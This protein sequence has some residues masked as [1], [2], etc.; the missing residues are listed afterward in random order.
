MT[1]VNSRFGIWLDRTQ[2]IRTI[3]KRHLDDDFVDTIQRFSKSGKNFKI[4]IKANAK[5]N[6][7]QTEVCSTWKLNRILWEYLFDFWSQTT[8]VTILFKY[9][10]ILLKS[11]IELYWNFYLILVPMKDHCPH[12]I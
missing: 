6:L 12:L 9:D 4:S 10:S 8:I 1:K 5:I 11:Q 3:R 7:I 2:K